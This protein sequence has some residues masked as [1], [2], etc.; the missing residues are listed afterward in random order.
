MVLHMLQKHVIELHCQSYNI[1]KL[2]IFP[3]KIAISLKQQLQN[4]YHGDVYCR[5]KAQMLPYKPIPFSGSLIL[6]RFSPPRLPELNVFTP[7]QWTALFIATLRIKRRQ[8][9]KMVASHPRINL[10]VC[11]KSIK[12]NKDQALRSSHTMGKTLLLSLQWRGNHKLTTVI[13]TVMSVYVRWKGAPGTVRNSA[14]E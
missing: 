2:K 5:A 9:L 14:G 6:G 1:L 11:Q 7:A 4:I 10:F 3:F 12:K 13:S 8:I